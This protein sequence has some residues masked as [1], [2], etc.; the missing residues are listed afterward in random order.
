WPVPPHPETLYSVESDPELTSSSVSVTYERPAARPR[1]MGEQRAQLVD[2]ISG[3]LLTL[4]LNERAQKPDPPFLGAGAGVGSSVRTMDVFT[5]YA[6]A[7]DG[8][9]PEAASA[10]M[11]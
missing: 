2:V 7:K 1:T 4:R 11:D 10:L 5:L 6:Q 8:E 9:I 3:F